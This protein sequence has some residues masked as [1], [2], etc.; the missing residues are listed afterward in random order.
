MGTAARISLENFEEKRQ[1]ISH[2]KSL[3]DGT[4]EDSRTVLNDEISRHINE[5]DMLKKNLSDVINPNIMEKKL[6]EAKLT[7]SISEELADILDENAI[8]LL[9]EMKS[10]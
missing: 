9:T 2:V 6:G 7:L 10:D 4:S 5:L 8:E 1:K 3:I